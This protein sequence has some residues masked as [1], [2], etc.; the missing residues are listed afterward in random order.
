MITGSIEYLHAKALRA[1]KL[2]SFAATKL[3]A[4]MGFQAMA[5][6]RIRIIIWAQTF[7]HRANHVN[8]SA[9]QSC[10]RVEGTVVSKEAMQ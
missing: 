7:K 9:C 5:L 3:K 10:Q 2:T 8:I 6:V 1:K 4:S